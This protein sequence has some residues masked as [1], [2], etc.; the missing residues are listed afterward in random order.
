[1]AVSRLPCE[2]AQLLPEERVS[3]VISFLHPTE[4]FRH[5]TKCNEKYSLLAKKRHFQRW[6]WVISARG[7]ENDNYF[8]PGY[9]GSGFY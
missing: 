5:D 3:A 6:K 2:E 8:Y 4:D 1:L 9:P 7:I